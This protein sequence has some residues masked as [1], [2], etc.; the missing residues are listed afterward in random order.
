MSHI[1]VCGDQNINN[2]Q[3]A[4]DTALIATSEKDMQTLLD[5]I[6]EESERL[7]LSLNIKKMV[8]MVI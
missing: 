2:L 3:Y 7:G 4:D 5:I 8:T 1:Y 6:N